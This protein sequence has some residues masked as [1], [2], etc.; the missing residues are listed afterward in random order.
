MK[1]DEEVS[2]LSIRVKA[3]K[4]IFYEQ[5]WDLSDKVYEKLYI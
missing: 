2:G 4:Y 1:L 5:Q 3:F